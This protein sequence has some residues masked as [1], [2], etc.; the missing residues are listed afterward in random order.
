MDFF[1]NTKK[2][3]IFEWIKNEVVQEIL[4]H[5]KRQAF[6]AGEIIMEQWDM[7]DGNGYIIEN[8]EVEIFINGVL[9][10]HLSV[11]HIFGEIALL[12]EEERSATIIAKTP[13]TTIVLN[14]ETLFSMIEHDDNSINKEIMRRMEENLEDEE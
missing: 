7:P 8:W 13:I 10:A 4:N 6:A 3:K 11:W 5:S 12:N 9:S 2:L 14:Q 1:T